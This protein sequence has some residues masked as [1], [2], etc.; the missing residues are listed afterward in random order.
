[1]KCYKNTSLLKTYYIIIIIISYNQKEKEKKTWQKS[2]IKKRFNKKK[3]THLNTLGD[4]T[5]W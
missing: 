3:P 5:I 2:T 4:K 1:M